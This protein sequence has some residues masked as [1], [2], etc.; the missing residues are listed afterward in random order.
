MLFKKPDGKSKTRKKCRFNASAEETLLKN[1][2]IC[3]RKNYSFVKIDDADLNILYEISTAWI[4]T[5]KSKEKYK[6][7]KLLGICLCQGSAQHFMDEGTGRGLNDFDIWFFFEKQKDV[8]DFPVRLVYTDFFPNDKF[9]F[10]VNCVN[11]TGR[12]IDIMGRSITGSIE[13][14]VTKNK[15]KS[16]KELRKSRVI[17]LNK[18]GYDI[19]I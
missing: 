18:D 8:P 2:T 15:N 13:N 17:L 4:E 3:K 12:R 16:A 19:V 10:S 14:W 6:D 11:K 9:G 1:G 5:F 7:L